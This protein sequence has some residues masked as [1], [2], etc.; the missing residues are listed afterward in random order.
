[1]ASFFSGNRGSKLS[2]KRVFKDLGTMI[3]SNNVKI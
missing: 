1:M 3:R 2:F